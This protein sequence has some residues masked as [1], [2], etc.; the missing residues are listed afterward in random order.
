MRRRRG[1]FQ[2]SAFNFQLSAFRCQWGQGKR[3]AHAYIWRKRRHPVHGCSI[4]DRNRKP[5]LPLFGGRERATR[6]GHDFLRSFLSISS[7]QPSFRVITDCLYP[8]ACGAAAGSE[9]EGRG[10]SHFGVRWQAKRDTAFRR[11]G[12]GKSG[13]ARNTA[14]RAHSRRC[15][16]DG[17]HRGIVALALIRRCGITER[18]VTAELGLTRGSAVGYLTRLVKARC[19]ADPATAERVRRLTCADSIC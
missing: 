8:L 14:C 9:A 5:T 18:A 1:Q 13:V 12:R 16:R 17:L 7:R 4:V 15:R 6:A 19:R 3:G 2:L 11:P 10:A